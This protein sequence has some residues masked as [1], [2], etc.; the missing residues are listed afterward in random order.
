MEEA[1]SH[2]VRGGPFH[3]VGLAVPPGM[4]V[5][6]DRAEAAHS[7]FAPAR[8][9]SPEKCYRNHSAFPGLMKLQ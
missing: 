5:S 2:P 1:E 7:G 3:C 6:K 4:F 9:L 8:R